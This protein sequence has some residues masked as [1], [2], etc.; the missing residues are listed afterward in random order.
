MKLKINRDR[1]FHRSVILCVVVMLGILAWAVVDDVGS[2]SDPFYKF[3]SMSDEDKLDG[4]E[5]SVVELRIIL[6]SDIT[7]KQSRLDALETPYAPRG[8]L[9]RADELISRVLQ[10]QID[11]LKAKYNSL[12]AKFNHRK[13]FVTWEDLTDEERGRFNKLPVRYKPI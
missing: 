9:I 2:D 5:F 10:K 8:E 11:E 12:A 13:Q 6:H 7:V 1:W 4:L 3:N